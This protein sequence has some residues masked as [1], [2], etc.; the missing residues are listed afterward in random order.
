VT[1]HASYT[2]VDTPLDDLKSAVV[3]EDN[4]APEKKLKTE[5]ES[6]CVNRGARP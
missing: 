2:A 1:A 3:R 4:V 5:G 6:P